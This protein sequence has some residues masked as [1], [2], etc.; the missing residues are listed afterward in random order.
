M[1]GAWGDLKYMLCLQDQGLRQQ[2]VAELGNID[3]S[4]L[5]HLANLQVWVLR[6]P[7]LSIVSISRQKW[8]L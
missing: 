5:Q 8:N 1:Q 3:P 6:F 2:L 4:V 7:D